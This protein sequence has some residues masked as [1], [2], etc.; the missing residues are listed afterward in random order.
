MSLKGSTCKYCYIFLKCV[1]VSVATKF[2]EIK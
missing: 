1:C 2:G